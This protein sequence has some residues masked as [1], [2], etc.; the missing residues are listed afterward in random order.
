MG[1]C[2]MPESSPTTQI[3][4]PAAGGNNISR[5]LR[6]PLN[7]IQR[8]SMSSTDID[9]RH[10]NKT[11]SS[12]ANN[13]SGGKNSSNQNIPDLLT[14]DIPILLR[15]SSGHL[16]S[17]NNAPHLMQDYPGGN[18][19]ANNIANNNN[20]IL[21]SSDNNKPSLSNLVNGTKSQ[22][23]S[24]NTT[25]GNNNSIDQQQRIMI[26]W[27]DFVAKREGELTV[28]KGDRLMVTDTHNPDWCFVEDLTSKRSGFVPKDYVASE[29]IEMEEWFFPKINRREAEKLLLGDHNCRGTFL[30]RNSEQAQTGYSLS[31][32]DEDRD[33]GG[34]LRIHVKHYRIKTLDNG[35]YFVAHRNTF[36]TMAELITF[37]S[38][39]QNGL[40]YKL[41]RPCPKPKPSFWPDR[42]DEI[43]RSEL[44]QIRKIGTGCFGEVY[45]GCY[46]NTKEVA[47]KTLKQGT[48]SPQA[49]LEEAVIMRKCRHS[50]LVPL[51]GVCSQ[52]EPLLIVTE[53]MCNGSLLE[54]LRNNPEGKSLKL[55]DLMEMASQ[56]A[57][58]MAYLEQVKLIHRDL[59]ARNILVGENRIVKVAD[60]GLARVIEDSEYTARQGAKFPIKWTAP[61]AA[62]YGKFSI[63]SD[64]WSYGILLYELV[65]HGSIPY[66][67]MH[68]K[69]VIEQVQRGYRIPRP[70]NCDCPDAVYKKM[71]DCWHTDPDK[72]PTFEFLA[73]F[74]DNYNVSSEQS[75]RDASDCF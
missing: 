9:S 36:R 28:R 27:T 18:G 49:F 64:V 46:R 53:F 29:A 70:T 37:Y 58:G 6:L 57:Y 45:Y 16:N 68:N 66:A 12:K 42:S 11:S 55:P 15:S 43:Q 19:V 34:S 23:N 61:E 48:M 31:I 75:Y 7:G 25:N 35:G 40:C 63:K 74:F 14:G 59:A 67:G 44:R 32:R 26:C 1:N 10:S 13:W 17:S 8:L 69:E 50:N 30:V 22:T 47:I 39:A 21:K 62:M 56:I 38:K 72:R 51:Y 73:N 24:Y 3:G 60:F 65:T 41:V 5:L 2:L 71:R 52:E 4:D 54:Y 33:K 20:N